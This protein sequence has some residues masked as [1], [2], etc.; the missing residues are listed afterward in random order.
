[1]EYNIFY[2]LHLVIVA[3]VTLIPIYP[4][5]IIKYMFV[6]PCLIYLVWLVCDGC[7]LNKFHQGKKT[8]DEIKPHFLFREIYQKFYPNLS[9]ERSYNVTGFILTLIV[10]ICAIRLSCVDTPVTLNTEAHKNRKKMVLY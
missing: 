6:I 8:D 3:I 10:T 9:E 5:Y 2:V 4:I 1:M 7:P